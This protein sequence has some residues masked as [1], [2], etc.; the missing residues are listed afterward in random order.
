MG[1]LGP[2]LRT[3]VSAGRTL[4]ITTPSRQLAHDVL[5]D[6]ALGM[7]REVD[8]LVADT[9]LWESPDL[10]ELRVPTRGG[11]RLVDLLKAH[12]GASVVTPALRTHLQL[13]VLEALALHHHV[14]MSAAT[15]DFESSL[16]NFNMD[17]HLRVGST[18]LARALTQRTPRPRQVW[19]TKA[20]ESAHPWLVA[21]LLSVPEP[22]EPLGSFLT[23]LGGAGN[24][25]L[26]PTSAY[27]WLDADYLTPAFVP[28]TPAELE[29]L[30]K[31]GRHP[32]FEST[33]HDRSTTLMRAAADLRLQGGARE[34]ALV[35]LD[36]G[37]DGTLEELF[38]VAASLG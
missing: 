18:S 22:P 21:D 38:G 37:F 30:L 1:H 33:I 14:L 26:A 20:L 31:G 11:A 2:H 27:G 13:D 35:L 23:P 9:S 12:P 5:V 10:T 3:Q 29:L 24:L 28:P 16:G 15:A 19:S 17:L 36:E 7:H 32:Y 34:T 6:L 8:V 25:F 4:A